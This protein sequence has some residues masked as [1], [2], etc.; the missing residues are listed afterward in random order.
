[1]ICTTRIPND[2]SMVVIPIK[3]GSGLFQVVY[4]LQVY[5]I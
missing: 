5:K 1:M 3:L 2:P 4:L